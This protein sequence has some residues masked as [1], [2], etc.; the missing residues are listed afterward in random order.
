MIIDIMIGVYFGY[1][2]GRLTWRF[3]ERELDAIEED[4]K[5]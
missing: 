5:E 1:L 4:E 3:M 2:I